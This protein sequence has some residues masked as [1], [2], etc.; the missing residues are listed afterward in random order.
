MSTILTRVARQSLR[1][2][3]RR[4]FI[5]GLVKKKDPGTRASQLLMQDPKKGHLHG[6]DDPTYLKGDG[7]KVPAVVAAVL[8]GVACAAITRGMWNM[9]HGINKL[10]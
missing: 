5:D 10:D 9:S 3:Q 7:D 8:F 1:S 4:H 6:A 2:T